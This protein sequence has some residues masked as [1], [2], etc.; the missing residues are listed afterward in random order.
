MDGH[1]GFVDMKLLND[2]RALTIASSLVTVVSD[3]A[4]QNY[5]VTAV[6]TGSASNKVSML[7][8]MHT[9]SLPCQGRIPIVRI[10]C[11]VYITLQHSVAF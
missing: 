9:F 7:N 1:A 8:D 10:P 2:E 11:I 3:L 4:D 5:L 6:C